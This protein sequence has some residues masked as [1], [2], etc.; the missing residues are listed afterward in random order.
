MSRARE[1]NKTA[2]SV[3]VTLAEV[4]VRPRLLKLLRF[5]LALVYS[6][7]FDWVVFDDRWDP[8]TFAVTDRRILL[9]HGSF[10]RRYLDVRLS[11]IVDIRHDAP[12]WR[13][14]F[15]A[16]D[17]ALQLKCRDE[18]VRKVL[19]AIDYARNELKPA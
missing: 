17:A 19:N 5:P 12:R 15:V 10:R 11:D 1:V 13:L 3:R 18:S 8:W 2:L 14:I 7:S 4:Q 9:R 16:A 6:G